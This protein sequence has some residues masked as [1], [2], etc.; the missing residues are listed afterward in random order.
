MTVILD[1]GW[2]SRFAYDADLGHEAALEI[3]E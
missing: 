2:M 3:L 1:H